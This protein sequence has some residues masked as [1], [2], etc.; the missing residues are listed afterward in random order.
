MSSIAYFGEG[1]QGITGKPLL[2][3]DMDTN[4]D[5]TGSTSM[6]VDGSVTPVDFFLTPSAGETFSCHRMMTFVQD[7]GNFNVDEW[8]SGQTLVNGIE[9]IHSVAGAETIL[10]TIRSSGD[11]AGIMYDVNYLDFGN[12]DNVIVGR[13]TFTKMGSE[14]YLH[15]EHTDKLIIRIND[16]LTGLTEQRVQVQGHVIT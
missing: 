2:M 16:D 4:G 12:G 13:L 8:G 14:I 11:L 5:G 1:V 10:Q 9:L 15:D 3:R 7:G 6:A